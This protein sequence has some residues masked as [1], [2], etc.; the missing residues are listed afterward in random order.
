MKA[1]TNVELKLGAT[2]RT[3][4]INHVHLLLLKDDAYQNLYMEFVKYMHK[5]FKRSFCHYMKVKYTTILNNNISD[6]FLLL[7]NEMEL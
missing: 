4:Y 3:I 1:P 7:D 6:N 2:I 5:I